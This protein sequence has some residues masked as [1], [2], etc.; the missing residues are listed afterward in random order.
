M[1]TLKF[2]LSSATGMIAY[3]M[4]ARESI[5]TL[6]SK[7]DSVA[8]R[9]IHSIGRRPKRSEAR[10]M[11]AAPTSVRPLRRE[12][13]PPWQRASHPS[14]SRRDWKN[15][16]VTAEAETETNESIEANS[17]PLREASAGVSVTV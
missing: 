16:N 14:A 6:I 13:W 8:A 10:P 3:H 15:G 9:P 4:P 2:W 5:P 1:L 17:T 11:S 12:V 7:L